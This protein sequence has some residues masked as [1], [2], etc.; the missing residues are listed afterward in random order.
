MKCKNV[1][2]KKY[3]LSYF[4]IQSGACKQ[5][6]I[7]CPCVCTPV[8]QLFQKLLTEVRLSVGWQDHVLDKEAF[9][10]LLQLEEKKIHVT[11]YM[12]MI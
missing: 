9:Q 1:A 10:G 11:D 3:F 6:V 5:L 12:N 2:G 7:R 4:E 8:E